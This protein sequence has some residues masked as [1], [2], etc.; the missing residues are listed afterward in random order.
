MEIQI[1]NRDGVIVVK[2]MGRII[3]RGSSAFRR[4]IIDEIKGSTESPNFV[5]DFAGV[6]RIDSVGI[7]VLAGVHVSIAQRGGRVGIINISKNIR[8]TFVIA[9]LITTF[10]HF[11][12][13]N[14]AIVNLRAIGS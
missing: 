10:K 14:E 5:F 4:A 6:P 13:E 12:S 9:K 11:N 8:N 2:P 3:G 1:T 7:G